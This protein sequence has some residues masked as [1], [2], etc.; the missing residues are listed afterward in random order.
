[1]PWI[2]K[3]AKE[4]IFLSFASMKILSILNECSKIASINISIEEEN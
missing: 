3:M 2:Q 1:M 4:I